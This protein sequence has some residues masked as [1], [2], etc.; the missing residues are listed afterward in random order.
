MKQA[1]HSLDKK[2][3]E[4]SDIANCNVLID[5]FKGMRFIHDQ[6]Y[7]HLDIKPENILVFDTPDGIVGKICDFGLAE[8]IVQKQFLSKED[9]G[10]IGTYFYMAPEIIKERHYW[11]RS[12]LFSFGRMIQVLMGRM[13]RSEIE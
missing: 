13:K 12:D 3:L 9:E 5:V 6:N 7:V 10:C 1:I 11:K 8:E 2:Y 4:Q